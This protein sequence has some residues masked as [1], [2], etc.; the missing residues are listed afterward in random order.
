VFELLQNVLNMPDLMVWADLAVSAGGS[1]CWE[2]AFAGVPII[3]V[4]LAENQK[5]I[6]KTL[7]KNNIAINLGWYSKVTY[8]K[9]QNAIKM[10]IGSEA[11]RN[12]MGVCGRDLINGQGKY[13]V[14]NEI[15][16]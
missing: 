10:I 8:K 14:L 5:Y 16:N 6:A 7:D 11:K 1:T 4:E 3:I 2:L 9:I 13:K 12:M 15:Y